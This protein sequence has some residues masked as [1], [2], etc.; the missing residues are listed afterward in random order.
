MHFQ[1][2][3]LLAAVLTLPNLVFGKLQCYTAGS[4]VWSQTTGAE[5]SRC[6]AAHGVDK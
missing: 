5:S 3:P 6:N 4:P 1:A 2:L